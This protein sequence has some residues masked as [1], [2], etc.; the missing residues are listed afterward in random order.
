MVCKWKE[1]GTGTNLTYTPD[2][3]GTFEIEGHPQDSNNSRE[4]ITIRVDEEH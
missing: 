4:I 2:R 1:I 3:A